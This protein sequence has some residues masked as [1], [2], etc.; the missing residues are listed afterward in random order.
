MWL[1]GVAPALR[2]LIDEVTYDVGGLPAALRG[3]VASAPGGAE[4]AGARWVQDSAGADWPTQVQRVGT[5]LLCRAGA[6]RLTAR[7]APTA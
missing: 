4:P 5:Q 1:S 6:G 3:R 7:V 2:Q